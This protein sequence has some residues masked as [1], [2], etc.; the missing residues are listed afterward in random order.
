MAERTNHDVRLAKRSLSDYAF[1]V[2]LLL[3][4]LKILGLTKLWFNLDP[5]G[6]NI[7]F[8]LSSVISFG[9]FVLLWTKF[10][11]MSERVAKLEAKVK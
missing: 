11:S 7:S 2:L 8:D 9:L 6:I 4:A 1:W 3:L 5:E 10:D